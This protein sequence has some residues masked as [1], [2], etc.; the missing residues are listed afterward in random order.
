[1]FGDHDKSA[2]ARQNNGDVL[3]IEAQMHA[4]DKARTHCSDQA[5]QEQ[6]TTH[7]QGKQARPSVTELAYWISQRPQTKGEGNRN[8]EQAPNK[9]S[10][11]HVKSDEVGGKGIVK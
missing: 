8:N 9:I 6:K 5:N 4:F 3:H 2:Q 11:I 7:Q 10:V 1:M